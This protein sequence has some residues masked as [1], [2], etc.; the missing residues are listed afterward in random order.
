[1]C[2]IYMSKHLVVYVK[3]IEFLIMTLN[4]I[5]LGEKTSFGEVKLVFP[6]SVCTVFSGMETRLRRAKGENSVSLTIM[7]GMHASFIGSDTDKQSW[8][9]LWSQ[10]I[11]HH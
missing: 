6:S 9:K 2:V 7:K 8:V 5:S 3:Y 11:L 1:M 10:V 4:S